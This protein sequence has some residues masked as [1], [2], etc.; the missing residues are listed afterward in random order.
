MFQSLINSIIM[1]GEVNITSF[2]TR[3]NAVLMLE[4]IWLAEFLASMVIIFIVLIVFTYAG[5][6]VMGL[7][8][9]VLTMCFCTAIQWLDG[10]IL[11][12]MTLIVASLFTS[13]AMKRLLGG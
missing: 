1:A 4:N 11:I 7:I 13:T 2:P 9:S 3:L 8:M 12:F 5:S 10:W 6:V